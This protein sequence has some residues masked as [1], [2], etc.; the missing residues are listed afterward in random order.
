MKVTT[1]SISVLT[2]AL[3]I[4]TVGCNDAGREASIGPE[5]RPDRTTNV[6]TATN[7]AETAGNVTVADITG[8]MNN[9]LG[10]TVTVSGWVESTYGTNY[11]RLDEDSVFTGG[12]D[13][14]LLVIGKPNVI[15]A[16]L[17]SGDADSKVRV[18]GRVARLVI[19]DIQR[20]YGINLGADIEAEFRDKPVLIA[21]SVQ[22]I[23]TDE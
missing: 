7:A 23:K 18:N 6:N 10:K 12:I 15:P 17:K 4:F 11:F 13:N 20:D 3:L 1:I 9:Y 19:A 5:E 21:N 14:D 22:L 2:F 16:G 8:N